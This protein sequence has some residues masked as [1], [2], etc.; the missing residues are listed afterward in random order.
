MRLKAM[1]AL[2]LT[3]LL[4][5]STPAFASDWGCQVLLCL[6]SPRHHRRRLQAADLS[7]V[8]CLATR[9]VAIAARRNDSNA[10]QGR[11]CADRSSLPV[12]EIHSCSYFAHSKSVETLAS[13]SSMIGA[14]S[15]ST[16]RAWRAARS[17]TRG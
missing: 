1:P 13:T 8:G 14:G 11:R 2:A 3:A 15:V 16:L 5:Q 17:I 7:A 4:W 9:R 12:G 6:A 10:A